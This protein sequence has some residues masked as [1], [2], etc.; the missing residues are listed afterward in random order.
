VRNAGDDGQRA[1][2][3]AYRYL[4]RRD[5]TEAEVREH[6]EGRGLAAGDV[7]RSIATLRDQSYLDDARFARLLAQDKRT[8]EHWG[9]DRIR[10]TLSARGID[11]DLV[12]AAL[13]GDDASS[14]EL[15]R[16]VAVL[17]R[18]FPAPPQERRERDRALALLLRKGYDAELALD[19]LAKHASG[20]A[21][22]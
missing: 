22:G 1:L 20:Y 8:L 5:R 4:N 2:E 6:L 17:R 10:R 15:D 7:E 3:L 14:A 21:G 18:R 16:A 11:R 12:E 9:S 19:A 13:A